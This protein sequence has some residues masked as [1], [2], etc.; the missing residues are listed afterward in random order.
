M[1]NKRVLIYKSTDNFKAELIRA[2]LDD[3]EIPC[4][5]LNKKDS[6]Y[7]SFGEIEIYV[8]VEDAVNALHIINKNFE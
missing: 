1:E 7:L 4:F 5:L 8:N 6:S 2:V 3:N